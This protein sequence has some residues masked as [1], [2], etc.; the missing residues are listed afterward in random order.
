MINPALFSSKKQSWTTPKDFYEKLD[1]EFSFDFDPCI[2]EDKATMDTNGL[3]IEWGNCNFV[4]PPYSDV[5]KWVAKSYQECLKGKKV[6]MLIPSRTDTNWWHTYI[7][8]IAI[9]RFVKGR[10]IFG[11][12]AYWSWVWEQ[13]IINGKPNSLYKKYGKKNSAPFPS[14]VIIFDPEKI[15]SCVTEKKIPT[16]FG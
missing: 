12:D 11:N 13:P 3:Y 14:V 1:A 10:L 7:E 4:N 9:T 16:L 15:K 5:D 8:G 6:I 2:A